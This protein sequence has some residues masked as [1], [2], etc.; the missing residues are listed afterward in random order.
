VKHEGS[1][2]LASLVLA[3]TSFLVV[4]SARAAEP[5]RYEVDVTVD[6][7]SGIVSGDVTIRA[8]VAEG[9]AS[10][11]LW[12]YADRLAVA[13]SPMEERSWRWIYP[14]EIDLGGITL[15]ALTVDGEAAEGE[16][17]SSPLGDLRGRDFGGSDLVLPVDPGPARTVVVRFAMRLDVPD[18]FGRLGRAA[19]VLSLAAPWYPL[20][21]DGDAW[22]FEVPHVVH[23]S[24]THGEIATSIARGADIDIEQ[25]GAYVP[26]IAASRFSTRTVRAGGHDVVVVSAGELYTPPSDDAP[27]LQGIIDLSG[28]DLAGMIGQVAEQAYASAA[29]LGIAVP[30]PLT[31]LVVPSRTELAASAPGVLLVSDHAL[32]IFPLDVVREFHLRAI[33]RAIFQVLAQSIS[34]RV[35]APGDRG[36]VD[37]LRSIVLL[38]LDE[39]RRSSTAQRPDQLL[40]LFAF[41]PAVDQL[42]YAPQIA[43]EEIY[44]GAIDEPDR[45]RDD[46]V[47]ARFPLTRGR[48]L[49]ECVRDVLDDEAMQRTVARIAN[50]RRSIRSALARAEIDV[51]A[52]LPFWLRYATLEVNYRLG[53]ITTERTEAGFRHTIEI[54]RE[55]DE[56]PE[57]VEVEVEDGAGHRVS[58]YWDGRGERGEVVIDTPA[59]RGSVTID[60]RQRL[61]QSARVSD[62]HP[63]QDD[64]TN[65][66]WRPP[67][68]TAFALDVLVSEQNVTGVIDLALRQR[69]D[70]EHTVALRLAR[71]AARTGG[72]IVYIQGLGP[73]AHNN[74]RIGT[75]GGGIG[76]NY[77]QPGFG[78]VL[79]LGGYAIDAQLIGGV[80]TRRFIYDPREAFVLSAALQVTGTVR[81]DSTFAITG[82]GAF[83]ATGIFPVGL[84]NVFVLA[85]G[86]GFT[87][88]PALDADR[89]SIGGRYALRGFS[90]SQLLGNGALY[91]VLEHRFTVITDLGINILW[92]VIAR[93]VQLAWWV[94]GGV[95]FDTS[96]HRDAHGAFEA[97]GGLRF[98][99]EYGGIQ[100]GVLAIDIGVPIS[101][102]VEGNTATPLGFYIG[103]D[104]Y[105]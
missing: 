19:G 44:F 70:L 42:L 67:I 27:S 17:L 57:P 6:P 97:G 47:R 37:D 104:Q 102:Y 72:R 85:G 9:E 100:P 8:H 53:T 12:L 65:A 94:G 34:A 83:H 45:F 29:W 98:H 76:F 66:P 69:Y 90:N 15:D 60:P 13:P 16:L 99:Y 14:G 58:G 87:I 30:E 21:V 11:T 105:Y 28:I 20:V 46:P 103:F 77:V 63:R 25:V 95:V 41:H 32:Q 50:G 80:D 55:G 62:G 22:A 59:D 73:K 68:I 75:L 5:E 40:S 35:E 18:R 1:S 26:A 88:G 48:R 92:G 96:D 89:Q 84:L 38:D 4:A 78:G 43:F 36:W 79:N 3:C 39:A 52:M 82:R 2:K 93:E 54:L 56:R 33:R 31:V 91:A 23:A 101:S 61:P 71:T 74:R 51:D 81:D 7:A 49:L 10:I 64:A 86:G 24:V